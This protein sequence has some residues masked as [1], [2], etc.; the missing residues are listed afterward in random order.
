MNSWAS[1]SQAMFRSRARRLVAQR[2]LY[3]VDKNPYAVDLA[4]L[5]LWLATLARDHPFTFLD[6]A[7]RHG[8]SLVGL[9]RDQISSFSWEPKQKHLLLSGV[10][11][12]NLMLAEESRLTLL[13]LG[14]TDD[15]AAKVKLLEDSEQATHLVRTAADLVIAA[16]FA[17]EKDKQREARRKKNADLLDRVLGDEAPDSDLDAET[18]KPYQGARPLHPFHWPIEFPEV[19]LRPTPGFDAFVGNPPFLGGK[20]ISTAHGDGYRDWLATLHADASSNTD[21]IAHFFRR[22]FGLLREGGTFGLIATNTIAQ[23]D[24]RAGGLRWICTHGGTIYAARKRVKWPAPGAA[25]IVSVV[26]VARRPNRPVTLER[27]ERPPS[28]MGVLSC[29]LNPRMNRHARIML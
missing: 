10:L 20:R 15:H 6:H 19:L 28:D 23:G 5:S 2:C 18:V 29:L 16:F 21:L 7:L 17:E 26:H 14:D 9:S 4:K 27:D 22:A 24:T 1:A 25:V 3:G 12:R 8:D 11:E 13:A